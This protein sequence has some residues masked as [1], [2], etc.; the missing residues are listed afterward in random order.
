MVVVEARLGK[1]FNFGAQFVVM[2]CFFV[3][4]IVVSH[5]ARRLRNNLQQFAMS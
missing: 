1:K 4:I 5:G 2:N 3:A